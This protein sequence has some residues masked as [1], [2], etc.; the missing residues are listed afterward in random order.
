MS[1]AWR[2]LLEAFDDLTWEPEELIDVGDRVIIVTRWNGHGAGSGVP[3]SN[4]CSRST[5]SAGDW[6]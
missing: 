4:S 3:V 2:R 5:P 6:W 1:Q